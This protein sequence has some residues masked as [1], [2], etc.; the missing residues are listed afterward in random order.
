MPIVIYNRKGFMRFA[1]SQG[2]PECMQCDQIGRF[3][4]LWATFS[5]EIIFGQLS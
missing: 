3:D 4:G 5:G 2:D 1:T